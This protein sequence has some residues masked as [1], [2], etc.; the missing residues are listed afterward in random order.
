MNGIPDELAAVLDTARS[1]RGDHAAP[2]TG[3]GGG[4]S[5]INCRADFIIALVAAI[6]GDTTNILA[7]V[8]N[9]ESSAQSIDSKLP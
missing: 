1:T 9:I 3:F 6:K 8:K 5:A 2:S 7:S 4:I